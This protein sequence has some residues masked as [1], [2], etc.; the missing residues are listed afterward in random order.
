MDEGVLRQKGLDPKDFK[1]AWVEGYGL[2]IGEKATLEV[3]ETE[4]VFGS[5]MNLRAEELN[6][7]YGE[8]SVAD[9]VP[10]RLTATDME[11]NRIEST[12][13]ILPMDLLSGR[14]PDYARALLLA[15]DKIGLPDT[16]LKTIKS[17]I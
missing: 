8:E 11:N 6:L 4:Q 1:L 7:L 5:I 2:R 16:Y 14:N 13:Y 12:S 17:W 15:A 10:V 9:Y 3:S